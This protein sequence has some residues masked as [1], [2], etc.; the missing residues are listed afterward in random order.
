MLDQFFYQ[1]AGDNPLTA[2]G[3]WVLTA[4]FAYDAMY[5]RKR[6]QNEEIK[7]AQPQDC[8]R[9]HDEIKEM[10]QRLIDLQETQINGNR[11]LANVLKDI[12]AELHTTAEI[13]KASQNEILA[14]IELMEERMKAK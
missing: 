1:L 3:I 13:R 10:N 4:I 5:L 2:L 9:Q 12:S 7:P 8:G 14:R 6:Q 11:M